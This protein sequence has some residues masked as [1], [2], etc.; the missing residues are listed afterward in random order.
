MQTLRQKALLNRQANLA[1]INAPMKARA[2]SL[3]DVKTF[4]KI[5]IDGNEIGGYLTYT[6]L[7]AKSYFIE[8]VR[9]TTGVIENF[10]SY[11]T[12]LTPQV[13][14]EFKYM[15]IAT[16]RLL[17]KIIYE[18]NEHV[19]KYYDIV[20]DKMVTRKMYFKPEQLPTIFQRKLEILAV[21]DYKVELVG[22]NAELDAYSITYH[23]NPPVDTISDIPTVG[24]EDF[25]DGEE[26]IMGDA[27]N[28]N[29]I[30]D[31]AQV[32]AEGYTFDFWSM[33]PTET[34]GEKKYQN[35]YAYILDSTAADNYV[36]HFYARWTN[37]KEW[38]LSYNYGV[39]DA[40]IDESTNE[41]IYSKNL[42]VGDVYGEF[43]T[44][45][46]PTVEYLDQTCEP[47]Y[48]G[49]WYRSPQ[50]TP[51]SVPIQPTDVY[52]IQGNSTAYLLYKVH[53]YAIY[54]DTNG[55]DLPTD[56]YSAIQKEYG[57]QI[58]A[59]QNPVRAGYTFDGWWLTDDFEEGTRFT[60]STMP[61]MD[62]ILTAK[63]VKNEE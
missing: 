63:W 39:A 29:S 49:A 58:Y 59:P 61:P 25:I 16:Y 42:H 28:I 13:T 50:I 37:N 32:E 60:F 46:T 56:G 62:L 47:Y 21:T 31:N 41:P 30:I 51:T 8:P 6:A 38:T 20:Y 53:I 12:F 35:G 33:N 3:D 52:T 18:R 2:N 5:W 1:R 40:A 55:A 17:L 19:V 4:A 48:D 45:K 43:P 44:V 57:A 36:Y 9:S 11:A 26:I 7:D 23:L 24:S 15:N 14:L 27:E 22:T 54:F 34:E 10:N